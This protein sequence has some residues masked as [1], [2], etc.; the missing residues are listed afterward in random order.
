MG[1][2][3]R[4]PPDGCGHTPDMDPSVPANAYGLPV[5][6]TTD[7]VDLQRRVSNHEILRI[8]S[9]AAAMHSDSL[10]WDL[11]AYR[12]LGAWWVVRRHEV[13]YL[14]PAR[15]DDELVCYTWPCGLRKAR[16][17]RRHVLER[18]ADGVV[19]ARGLNTW[20]LIDLETERP[21]RIPQEVIDAFDPARW[22]L[23][24]E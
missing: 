5:R 16:A 18:P 14:Q 8:F 22:V 24:D 21:R 7:M 11:D 19:I 4:P 2:R 3:G 15:M 10:G 23:E 9:R 17:M 13:D 1:A 20:A 6:V 12:E